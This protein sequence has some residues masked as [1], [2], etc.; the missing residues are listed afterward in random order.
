[1]SKLRGMANTRKRASTGRKTTSRSSAGRSSGARS[2]S[3]RRRRRGHGIAGLSLL[4]SPRLPRLPALDQRQR[5]VIGLA[6]VAVGV[7]L[8]FVLYGGS[9]TP[10]GRAGHALA[11]ALGWTLG[12][13]RVA[14]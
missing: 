6:L 8:G 13:G 14:P 2:R 5:D 11:V 9:P 4:R 1:M 7:F 10:G 3:R 12:K